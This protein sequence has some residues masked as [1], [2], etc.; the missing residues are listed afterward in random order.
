MN[1]IKVPYPKPYIYLQTQQY[2]PISVTIRFMTRSQWSHAGFFLNDRYLSA[3]GDGVKWRGRDKGA[4][5]LLLDAPGLDVAF[6]YAQTQIGKKYDF[7]ALFGFALDR[8]WRDTSK[9]FCS[10]LVAASFENGETPNPLF[11]KQTPIYRIDPGD[12]LLTPYTT[13]VSQL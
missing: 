7:S 8:N 1:D 4:K 12:L 6:A 9:W 3:Q 2:N 13:I 11:N 5:I 10:E